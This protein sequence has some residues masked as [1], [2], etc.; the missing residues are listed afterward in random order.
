M[1]ELERFSL[2][3]NNNTVF[4]ANKHHNEEKQQDEWAM[5]TRENITLQSSLCESDLEYTNQGN[6]R[7][8]TYKRNE[9]NQAIRM[10]RKK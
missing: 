1:E 4:N 3:N 8:S 9:E 2:S 5:G 7:A 10:M 6:I